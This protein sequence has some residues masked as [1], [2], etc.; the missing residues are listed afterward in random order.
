[1]ADEHERLLAV[2]KLSLGG[3][4]R[5]AARP[6]REIVREDDASKVSQFEAR[7]CAISIVDDVV[8]H[9]A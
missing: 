7:S 5:L 1:M 6:A 3:R 9:P 4:R 2:D 8:H